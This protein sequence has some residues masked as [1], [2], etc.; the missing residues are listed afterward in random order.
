VVVLVVLALGSV[1]VGVLFFGDRL[2]LDLGSLG[3]R[4]PGKR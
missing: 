4:M 1:A 2:G 3:S